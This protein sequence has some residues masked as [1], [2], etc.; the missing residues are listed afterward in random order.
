MAELSI[1]TRESASRSSSFTGDSIADTK[2]VRPSN[3]PN[4]LNS[5]FVGREDELRCLEKMLKSD[6]PGTEPRR[7]AVFGLTGVGKTQL[8]IS[9]K[10]HGGGIILI[11]SPVGVEV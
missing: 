4:L 10:L 8:V 11:C 9:T 7:A 2:V 5:K 1:L 3:I 6:N